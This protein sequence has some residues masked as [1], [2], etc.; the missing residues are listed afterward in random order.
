[1]TGA[2]AFKAGFSDTWAAVHGSIDIQRVEPVLPVQ[3]RRTEPDHDVR[4]ADDQARRNVNGEI[5]VFAQDRWTHKRLTLN[6]GVRYD[7]FKGGY[8]EQTSVPLRF[9]RPAI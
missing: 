1:M 5:G 9:S 7:P 2:H 4:H 6:V 3:Q 8:P